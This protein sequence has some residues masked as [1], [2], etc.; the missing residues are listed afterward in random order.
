MY[1]FGEVTTGVTRADSPTFTVT[2][3][4]SNTAAGS[5]HT[6]TFIVLEVPQISFSRLFDVET[7]RVAD[8]SFLAVTKPVFS[9]TVTT[10][11]SLDDHFGSRPPADLAVRVAL[12][13]AFAAFESGT[14]RSR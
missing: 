7:V 8:P 5:F 10:D 11:V 6:L 9:S 13:T 3:A 1:D 2:G 4:T 12:L 14:S